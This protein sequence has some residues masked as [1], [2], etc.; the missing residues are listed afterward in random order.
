MPSK[1]SAERPEQTSAETSPSKEQQ[2]VDEILEIAR[3]AVKPL[4]KK[5]LEGE[6]VT[7]EILN[8]RLKR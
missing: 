3:Q 4:V 7:Q 6:V 5:E 8:L 2:R 1:D